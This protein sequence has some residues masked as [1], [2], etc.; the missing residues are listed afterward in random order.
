MKNKRLLETVRR[1][2]G[3]SSEPEETV[4]VAIVDGVAFTFP[5]PQDGALTIGRAPDCDVQL[6]H[7]S[8]SRHHARLSVGIDFEIEDLGSSNGTMVRDETLGAKQSASL[9]PGE[10]VDLGD[11]T[12]LL[13]Q[14][15][16]TRT[17]RRVYGHSY[18][19]ARLD[20][21]CS[22]RPVRDLVLVRVRAVSVPPEG[23]IMAA[24]G[25][26]LPDD[27]VIGAY[28]PG[29]LEALLPTP[30]DDDREL[31]RRLADMAAERGAEVR[32]GSARYP[33]QAK[34]SH[35]LMAMANREVAGAVAASERDHHVVAD[36]AMERLHKMLEKVAVGRISVLLLGETGV[37]KEVLARTL[38]RL[39]PR[40]KGPFV[41]FNCAAFTETLLESELF[42]H[43]KGA[44]TGADASR[45]GL[46][47]S[48]DGGTVFLDEV[49]ELPTSVQVKLLRVLEE[50]RVL[51]VGARASKDIDIR[52]VSA[53]NRD[54]EQEVH[55]GAFREDLLYRLN[56]VT[57]H[58][59]PL[60][61]RR[62][63][64][65]PLCKTFIDQA[66]ADL[67]LPSSPT[68]S[69]EA[70]ELIHDYPW[71]G[72]I[73]ELRNVIE[74]AVLLCDDVIEPG[75]LPTDKFAAAPPAM[76]SRATDANA[77]AP[78][79]KHRIIE[80]LA[81]CGGNQTRAARM[82]GI[83]R[84]TLSNKLNQYD[85]PRPLKGK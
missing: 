7:S 12:L 77:P 27:A 39:S 69:D 2:P 84:R 31:L 81:E 60:R 19:E 71:P 33:G 46:L 85:L 26:V 70:R 45:P 56:G 4:L 15:A 18:F 11:V 49:G 72:N 35:A 23:A 21:E 51:R 17:T 25:E 40:G 67:A 48:A 64:L 58:I 22:R 24:L 66:A 29:E 63:E 41:A 82:L 44:F 79:E 68:M 16:I 62:S 34:S 14:R 3:G 43:E 5:L 9:A 54:L 65:D 78:S 30:P 42:G 57:L 76:P 83:S 13:Q 61:Q 28:G 59:P 75:D 80:A 73:R 52:I 6:Q 20:D 36:P 38:H 53:T 74:R 1:P 55:A 50:K 37:G 10:S 32:V 47:E 8:I